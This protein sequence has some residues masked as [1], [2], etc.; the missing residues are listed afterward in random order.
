MFRATTFGCYCAAG[1]IHSGASRIITDTTEYKFA[2]SVRK[3]HTDTHTYIQYFYNPI[4]YCM[5]KC[6][7]IS[8]VV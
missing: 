5:E 1:A 6:D 3:L 8:N 4:T 2:H 7:V